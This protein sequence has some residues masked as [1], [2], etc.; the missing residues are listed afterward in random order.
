LD[1]RWKAAVA[2]GAEVTSE[3]AVCVRVHQIRRLAARPRCEGLE[4]GMA[5]EF[6][7]D[8][9]LPISVREGGYVERGKQRE[10]LAGKS[11]WIQLRGRRSTCIALTNSADFAIM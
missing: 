4:A 3:G 7:A 2:V 11:V 8:R 6:A 9:A 1:L 5:Y 10:D